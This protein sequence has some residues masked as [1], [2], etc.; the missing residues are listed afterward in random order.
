MRQIES[1]DELIL[2]AADL[3]SSLESRGQRA[4]A[5]TLRDG[6][7]CVDGLTDGWALLLESTK[8]LQ[9]EFSSS[10]DQSQRR[11]LQQIAD[12]AFELVYRRKSKQWWR[13]WQMS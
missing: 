13:F 6:L 11:Q 7:R 4:A 10:L 8:T 9:A 3:I 12:A 2:A 5:N 1:N